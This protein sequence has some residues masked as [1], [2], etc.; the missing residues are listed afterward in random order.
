MGGAKLMYPGDPS[1]SAREIY[2]CRCRRQDI[3]GGFDKV[4]PVYR[5]DQLNG[6][7]IS[8]MSYEE[9]EQAKNNVLTT[10]T[11]GSI[12]KIFKS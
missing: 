7:L 4:E 8:D 6:Q 2:N 3:V 10:G 11:G 12:V 5:R 1:G 9:W